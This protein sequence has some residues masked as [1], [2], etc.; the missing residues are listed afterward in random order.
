MRL[1]L[2]AMNQGTV[3]L[4]YFLIKYL[5]YQPIETLYQ[6]YIGKIFNSLPV[7]QFVNL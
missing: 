3:F 4:S 5:F 1:F 7:L 2:S 6:I